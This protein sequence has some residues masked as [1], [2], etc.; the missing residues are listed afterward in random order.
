[1]KP[2]PFKYTTPNANTGPRYVFIRIGEDEVRTVFDKMFA[3]TEHCKPGPEQFGL[4]GKACKD[5]HARMLKVCP[6]SADLSA[7]ERCVRLARMLA[8]EALVTGSE[9]A[10]AAAYDQLMLARM[11]AN[12][13]IA[14]ADDAELPAWE[15]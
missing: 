6:R 11:Q 13:S 1:M 3:H 4:I 7:A 9:R 8:N 10:K 14:L 12:A 2:D 15:A 5:M